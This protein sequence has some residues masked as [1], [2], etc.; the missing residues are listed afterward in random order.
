MPATSTPAAA[1]AIGRRDRPP[2][3]R[4]RRGRGRAQAGRLPELFGKLASGLRAS[5]R[6][7]LEAPHDNP[8]DLGR[9]HGLGIGLLHRQRRV[10]EVR[11]Q[12]RH[13][14]PAKR[15]GAGQKVIEHHAGGVKVAAPVDLVGCRRRARTRQRICSGL[16]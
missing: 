11:G 16:M 5:S 12:Q 15:Q 2:A 9:D 8:L 7:L 14:A 1:A 13:L 3:A 6:V 4:A 10:V